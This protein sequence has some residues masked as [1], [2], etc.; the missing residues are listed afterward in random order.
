MEG[1]G[2]DS[3]SMKRSRKLLLA[4]GA[5]TELTGCVEDRATFFIAQCWVRTG[6]QKDADSVGVRGVH[7]QRRIPQFVAKI[8]IRFGGQQH[9]K[10]LWGVSLFQ[11]SV[12]DRASRI[13]IRAGIQQNANDPR[14]EVSWSNTLE[15]IQER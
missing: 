11:G 5:A 1:G 4:R 3:A 9:A 10:N 2:I 15:G 6:R 8:W 12:A 7:H 14:I 13:R